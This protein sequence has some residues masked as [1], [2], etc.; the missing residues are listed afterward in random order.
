MTRSCSSWRYHV[1][2]LW[3]ELFLQTTWSPTT[4][5]WWRNSHPWT[6]RETSPHSLQTL[7]SI[8]HMFFFFAK[9]VHIQIYIKW[10]IY[11]RKFV[12]GKKHPMIYCHQNTFL[13]IVV[14]ALIAV[15]ISL[16]SRWAHIF[17]CVLFLFC[18]CDCPRETG[19]FHNQICRAQP[20][21]VVY[22]KGKEA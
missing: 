16:D 9:L 22:R 2:V 8:Q 3:L 15:Q 17:E 21:E 13:R 12:K 4:W 10:P 20:W 19:L 7:P 5:P 14:L 6:Q 1:S 11:S 18:Q